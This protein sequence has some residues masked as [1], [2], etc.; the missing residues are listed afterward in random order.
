[1]KFWIITDSNRLAVKIFLIVAFKATKFLF[2]CG[3]VKIK[4][5]FG[6]DFMSYQ[7]DNGI[8]E[9]FFRRDGRLNRWRYFKRFMILNFVAVTISLIGIFFLNDPKSDDFT[10]SQIIYV[11]FIT[12]VEMIPQFC[13]MSRRLHDMDNDETIAILIVVLCIFSIVDNHLS[14]LSNYITFAL[15]IIQFLFTIYV[16]FGKGT[17]GKNEYGADPLENN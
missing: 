8:M 16:L 1:M 15:G 10:V 5:F 13:I 3:K 4:N 14:I 2:D 9:N 17:I 11:E 7:Q 6:D 12:L